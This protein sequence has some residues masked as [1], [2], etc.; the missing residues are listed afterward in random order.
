MPPPPNVVYTVFSFIGFVLCAIP[1]YWHLEG[2]RNYLRSW[3]ILFLRLDGT[4]DSLEYGYMLV[5]DL[6]RSWVL[7]TMYQLHRMEQEHNQQGSGLL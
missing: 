5:H 1:F 3:N 7:A 6:D 2:E 4:P